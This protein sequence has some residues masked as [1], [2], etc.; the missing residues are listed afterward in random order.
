[1]YF[2]PTHQYD[3]LSTQTILRLLYHNRF[4]VVGVTDK[5]DEF[6][7]MVALAVHAP[8][9]DFVYK[10][11]KVVLN[12]PNVSNLPSEIV[13]YLTELTKNDT[14]LYNFAKQLQQEQISF[15]EDFDSSLATFLA[16]QSKIDQSCTFTETHSKV[17]TG[18]DCYKL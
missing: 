7:T 4:A 6:M 17:N 9:Q 14:E 12:R 8:V 10:K 2:P 1:M 5:F 11:E 18:L 3:E 16:A 13:D 15:S